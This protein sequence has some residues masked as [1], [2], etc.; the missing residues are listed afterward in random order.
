MGLLAPEFFLMWEEIDWCWRIRHAGYR[1]LYIPQALVWH[2]ISRSFDGGNR[3]PSWQYYYFRNRL[4]FL[5]RH[6]PLFKRM[7]FYLTVL[8]KELFQMIY[9]SFSPY[10]NSYQKTL[11]RSALKGICHYFMRRFG[12]IF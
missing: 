1:C 2:K 4:L 5:K 10:A 7:R 12:E 9:F 3:G 11:N 6:F 8:I